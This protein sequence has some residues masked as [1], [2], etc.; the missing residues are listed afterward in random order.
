MGYDEVLEWF[1]SGEAQPEQLIEI[2]DAINDIVPV[3]EEREAA[4]WETDNPTVFKLGDSEV[5]LVTRGKAQLEQLARAKEWLQVYAKP[6]VQIVYPQGKTDSNIGANEVIDL[7]LELLDTEA[8]VELGC[9]VT[10]RDAE[11]VTEHFDL[12]WVMAGVGVIL[13]QQSIGKA[14]TGFFGRRA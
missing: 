6:A 5:S 10:G 11:F 12:G 1:K 4:W 2:R 3:I 8:L 13:K 14:V 9:V 7:V